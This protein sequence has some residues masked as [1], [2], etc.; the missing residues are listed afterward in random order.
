MNRVKYEPGC[1]LWR[2]IDAPFS[3]DCGL[4]P[5]S[6][7]SV[8]Q[9]SHMVRV[10]DIGQWCPEP[11]VYDGSRRAGITAFFSELPPDNW[12]HA[13]VTRAGERAIS[14]VFGMPWSDYTDWRRAYAMYMEKADPDDF[15]SIRS[16]ARKMDPS[17]YVMSERPFKRIVSNRS[18]STVML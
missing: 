14:I 8:Q 6:I 3:P 2:S 5:V 9:G 7:V 12:T 1:I 17:P 10:L 13:F 11:E 16:I 15:D 4:S 18:A